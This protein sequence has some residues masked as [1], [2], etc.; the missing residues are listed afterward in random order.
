MNTITITAEHAFAKEFE[1]LYQG[2][3]CNLI[4]SLKVLI[5]KDVLENSTSKTEGDILL[6][7]QLQ[8]SGLLDNLDL[9]KQ[10]NGKI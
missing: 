8:Q 5:D 3:R 1:I 10:D 9:E 2:K 7:L 6:L 4:T